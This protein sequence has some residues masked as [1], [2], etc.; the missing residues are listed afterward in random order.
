MSSPWEQLPRA[1]DCCPPHQGGICL[2][3]GQI[4]R[5]ALLALTLLGTLA[6]C[7]APSGSSSS[8][9]SEGDLILLT[10]GTADSGGTMYQAGSAIAQA[11]TQEDRSIQINISAST[12]S[13]MNVRSLASGEVDLALVSGDVAHAA[14]HG[15]DEFQP[16]IE[17]RAIAAVYSSVSNWVAPAS[18]GYTYVHD[19]TEARIGVGP[20]G[21]TTELS[22]RVAVAALSLEE[23]GTTLVNCGLGDGAEMLGKGEL[24]AVHAFTGMPVPSL[25]ALAKELPCRLLLYTPEELATILEEHLVYYPAQIPAG[26]YPG[27][28]EAVDTFGVKC[29]LC[30]SSSMPE[31]LAYQLTQ[32]IWNASGRMGDYSPAMDDMAQPDFLCQDLPIPLHPGAERFYQEAGA[33]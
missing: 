5:K 26:T 29:L 10:I 33:L 19:L 22:A 23:Q 16:P 21:S 24:D 11:I 31:E 13:G 20:Q 15:E 8:G 12:G 9:D 32:A 3:T 17:L 7:G 18:S 6:G 27:Q 28:S 30:V 1:E 2:R 4:C 25:V 14:V